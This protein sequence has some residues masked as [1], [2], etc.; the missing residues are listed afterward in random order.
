MSRHDDLV[1]LET[2]APGLES[3]FEPFA[4]ALEQKFDMP[5]EDALATAQIVADTFGNAD[6]VD[7]DALDA[8]VRSIFYTLENK[9]LLTFRRE[10]YTSEG[11]QTLRAYFWTI[12]DEELK[13]ISEELADEA[14]EPGVY[15][16][17]PGDVWSGRNT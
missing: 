4:A 12:R 5:E 7:D 16:E 11:G 8:E 10:E 6:E 1:A 14:S 2:D 3:R 13:E 15:D 17:L 9:D